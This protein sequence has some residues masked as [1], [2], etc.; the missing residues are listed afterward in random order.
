M[1]SLRS[2]ETVRT[3]DAVLYVKFNEEMMDRPRKVHTGIDTMPDTIHN[4]SG[5]I[6]DHLRLKTCILPP[7]LLQF[8]Y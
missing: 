4:W 5:A 2:I 1:E 7:L 8:R 6:D 3:L